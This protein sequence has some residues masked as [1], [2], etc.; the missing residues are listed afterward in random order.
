MAGDRDVAAFGRRAQSYD[1]GWRGLLHHQIADRVAGLALARVPAPARVFDIG[2]GT[3]YLLGQLA[4]HLPQASA[5]A[6]A[7]GQGAHQ[8]A[9]DPAADGSGAALAALAPLLRRHHPGGDS[10]GQAVTATA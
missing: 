10:H 8:T 7:P 6:G 2:C 4:A 3:G 5:L 1:Q 9:G